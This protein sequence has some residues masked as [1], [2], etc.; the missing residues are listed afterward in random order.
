MEPAGVSVFIQ[1]RSA[2]PAPSSPV[3]SLTRGACS[4]SLFERTI[5]PSPRLYGGPPWLAVCSCSVTCLLVVYPG[6]A[7]TLLGARLGRMPLTRAGPCSDGPWGKLE[8]WC[9]SAVSSDT[10][11]GWAQSCIIGGHT[12]PHAGDTGG[13]SVCELLTSPAD[14]GPCLAGSHSQ[15]GQRVLTGSLPGPAGPPLAVACARSRCRQAS[16]HTVLLSGC[17]NRR[18]VLCVQWLTLS[19][20]LAPCQ[21]VTPP[22]V[23]LPLQCTPTVSPCPVSRSCS[24]GV[25]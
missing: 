6:S 22:V 16:A 5:C 2:F 18:P 1:L 3:P 17:Y 23:L 20:H 8:L 13:H 9:L 19:W 11:L 14:A 12:L 25:T 15:A 7:V 4:Q 21:R 24:S 10:V